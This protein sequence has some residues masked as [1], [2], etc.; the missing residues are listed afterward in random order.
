MRIAIAV[1]KISGS[2]SYIPCDAQSLKPRDPFAQEVAIIDL[3]DPQNVCPNQL[4]LVT[5]AFVLSADECIHC[6]RSIIAAAPA[7]I[8]IGD[9]SMCKRIAQVLHHC[10]VSIRAALSLACLVVSSSARSSGNSSAALKG[11]VAVV[12]QGC[13]ES[14]FPCMFPLTHELLPSAIS[15]SV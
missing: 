5:R 1:E 6:D 14:D 4:F 12:A 9:P 13:S 11:D 7:F 3:A 15:V 8:E 10:E 2:S